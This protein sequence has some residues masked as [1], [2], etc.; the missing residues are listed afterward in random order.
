M[1]LIVAVGENLP[2]ALRRE[3]SILEHLLAN[4][5]LNEFYVSAMGVK[6]VTQF[7]ATT[8]AQVVH[9]YPRMKILEIG[10]LLLCTS[11]SSTNTNQVPEQV[12]QRKQ[13]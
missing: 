2:R 1:K 10:R 12:E 3:T 6:E 8:V 11:I 13:L 7:L 4:N 9:R 5:L